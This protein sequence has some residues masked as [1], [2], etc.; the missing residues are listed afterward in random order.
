[1]LENLNDLY[2]QPSLQAIL[3][4]VGKCSVMLLRVCVCV[5][6]CPIRGTLGT[7]LGLLQRRHSNGVVHVCEC[8]CA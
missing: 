6:V 2:G 8:V 1:M 3:A 5:C 7:K 4:N